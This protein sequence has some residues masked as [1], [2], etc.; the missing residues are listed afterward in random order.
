MWLYRLIKKAD[1]GLTVTV[2]SAV[3]FVATTL[4]TLGVTTHTGAVINSSTLTQNGIQ[5]SNSCPVTHGTTTASATLWKVATFGPYAGPSINFYVGATPS[6]GT[7]LA[8]MVYPA[9]IGD[10]AIATA[11]GKMY[12]G[13]AVATFTDWKLVTSSA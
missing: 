11:T 3:T 13:G 4:S 1:D 7:P 5:T 8:S 9:N 10:I 12:I 2:D 6:Y